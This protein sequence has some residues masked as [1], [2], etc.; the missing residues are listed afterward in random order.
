MQQRHHEDRSKQFLSRLP[1]GARWELPRFFPLDLKNRRKKAYNIRLLFILIIEGQLC[2]TSTTNLTVNSN[3][4]RRIPHEIYYYYYYI[5]MIEEAFNERTYIRLVIDS[6]L[7]CCVFCLLCSI[8]LYRMP[9]IYYQKTCLKVLRAC[10]TTRTSPLLI[11]RPPPREG[12][13]IIIIV[14]L[15]YFSLGTSSR[16][17]SFSNIF[18]DSSSSKD[19]KSQGR[20]GHHPI[21]IIPLS[22]RGTEPQRRW[23][24]IRRKAD[25]TLISSMLP[26]RS[27][28]VK[29]SAPQNSSGPSTTSSTIILELL[30]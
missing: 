5:Y 27:R 26:A 22:E 17:T 23:Y 3:S 18:L 4:C 10:D 30:Q 11:N 13:F 19:G 21:I 12:S 6:F 2:G 20:V 16:N 24:R 7:N 8:I 28:P 15:L 29:I 9:P 1:L 14:L 25:F